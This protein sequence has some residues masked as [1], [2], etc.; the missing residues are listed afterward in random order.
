MTLGGRN[1]S[2]SLVVVSWSNMLN[3]RNFVVIWV[4]AGISHHAM[5]EEAAND[6]N[7]SI[8]LQ[9]SPAVE[10]NLGNKT[11]SRGGTVAVEFT[12][13]EDV[14]E[15]ETGVTALS[16]AGQREL[17]GEILFM[18]PFRLSTATE[19]MVGMGPQ[20]GRKFRGADTG[21]SFGIAFAMDMMFWP[22]KNLGWYIGP[23]YGYGVG[24]SSG[25]RSIGASIG[26]EF[27]L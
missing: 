10:R 15:I 6:E 19:L 27:G 5:C 18:K 12:P 25:E 13:V 2:I 17:S 14:L 1:N 3:L 7:H 8:V 24:K 9:L 23:E 26:I 11:F 22:A 16:S 21:T 20:A 4:L